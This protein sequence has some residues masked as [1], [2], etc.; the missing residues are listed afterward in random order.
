[1]P[2]C[3]GYKCRVADQER[4][5]IAPGYKPADISG[6]LEIGLESPHD[7]VRRQDERSSRIGKS[8]KVMIS[9][10]DFEAHFLLEYP[11]LPTH[12]RLRNVKAI[13]RLAKVQFT[14]D[15]QDV[16]Q[17]T[18]WGSSTHEY[19]VFIRMVRSGERAQPH[20]PICVPLR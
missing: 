15:R 16:L 13:R 20:R 6:P 8:H 12:G 10:E 14:G 2:E 17:F 19:T 9:A 7:V 18:E 11:D 4:C 3:C 1:M 5:G